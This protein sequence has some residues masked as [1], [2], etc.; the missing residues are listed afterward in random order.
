[1]D[2]FAWAPLFLLCV[3]WM[4]P[5]RAQ[6]FPQPSPNAK[7]CAYL[8]VAELEAHFGTKAQNLQGID[9][10]T[11]NTCTARFPDPFHV[12]SIES[13]PSAAADLAMTA[14][15]RLAVVKEAMKKEMVDTKDFGTVGCLKSTVDLGKPVRN[16][17]C[18]LANAPYLALTLQSV[19]PAQVS[20]DAA[21]SFLEKAAA[22]RK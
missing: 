9:Q 10:S 4:G 22:R 11:R 13:H 6:G 1:M 5:I 7:A 3:S 17:T 14:A 19:E 15:H 2:R 16:T 20:Y 8:P 18:F 12:V 21:K